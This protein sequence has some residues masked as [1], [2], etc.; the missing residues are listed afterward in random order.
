ME[1]KIIE[2]VARDRIEVPLSSMDQKLRRTR[3]SLGKELAEDV[4]DNDFQSERTFAYV[5][6]EDKDRARGMKEAV[7]E[8]TEEHPK[9]GAIL[10]GKIA[11]KRVSREEHLYFGMQPD[12]RL[13]SDDYMGVMQEIGISSGVARSLYPDLMNVSRKLANA[14]QEDRSVIVGKY[15][16][17]E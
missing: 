15:N 5:T 3:L 11:E 8:F 12:K 14:R 17:E 7:A 10:K 4:R 16:V 2:L 13:T 1:S 9:Y 6:T